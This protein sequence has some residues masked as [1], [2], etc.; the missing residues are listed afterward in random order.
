MT[1]FHN[2]MGKMANKCEKMVKN[3]DFQIKLI[4]LY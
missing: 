1:D 3:S 4:E 2:L